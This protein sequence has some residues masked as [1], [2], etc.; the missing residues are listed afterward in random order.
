VIIY[1]TDTESW[2]DHDLEARNSYDMY[3]VTKILLEDIEF[4]RKL[5][6]R[7]PSVVIVGENVLLE[8]AKKQ[9]ILW[10]DN[11]RL[12]HEHLRIFGMRAKIDPD[13]RWRLEVQ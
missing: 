9:Y 5:Y 2:E 7:E 12:N 13:N 6:Q 10:P 4:F 1:N 3:D 8:F 11:W